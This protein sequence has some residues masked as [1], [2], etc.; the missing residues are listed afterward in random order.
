[1]ENLIANFQTIWKIGKENSTGPGHE[2][3]ISWLPYK[4]WA[5]QS[6]DGGL[7]KS[8]PVCSGKI[9]V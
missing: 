9:Y 6:L 4:C 2:P 1:M 7:Q 8:Q 3:E 5:I